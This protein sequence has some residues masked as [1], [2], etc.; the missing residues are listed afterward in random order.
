[1]LASFIGVNIKQNKLVAICKLEKKLVKYGANINDLGKA[2]KKAVPG[3][4]FWY[5]DK[6]S[7]KD[8]EDIIKKHKFP[9]GVEWQGVFEEHTDGDDGHHSVVTHIDRTK[10]LIFISD[11]FRRFALVDRKFKL[12]FFKKRW[13][14]FNEIKNP[15]TKKMEQVKDI[16]MMFVVTPKGKT[17]PKEMGMKRI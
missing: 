7:I 9:V 5:K 14:D 2:V 1:M 8:I 6:S 4:E 3:G 16:R 12:D 15:K 17:F 11:P 13:W 10:N